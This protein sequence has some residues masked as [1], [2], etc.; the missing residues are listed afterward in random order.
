MKLK[1]GV[2]V[3]NVL[4]SSIRRHDETHTGQ[5]LPQ[6]MQSLTVVTCTTCIFYTRS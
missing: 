2:H 3:L 4:L 5:L 6:D 1:A